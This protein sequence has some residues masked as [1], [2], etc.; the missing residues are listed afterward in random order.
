MRLSLFHRSIFISSG[1][2][3]LV[4]SGCSVDEGPA[5]ENKQTASPIGETLDAARESLRPQKIESFDLTKSIAGTN[6]SADYTSDSAWTVVAQ[7]SGDQN[8]PDAGM[9]VVGILPND[10]V[11]PDVLERSLAGEYSA[12][13]QG[14]GTDSDESLC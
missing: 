10:L 3:C 8:N 13:I 11:S 1:I 12:L 6:I 7:C 5:S 9:I 2:A 4:L 14:W